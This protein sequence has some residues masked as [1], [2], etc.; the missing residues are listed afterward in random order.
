M[1]LID[2]PADLVDEARRVERR[3]PVDRDGEG[4]VEER[5]TEDLDRLAAVDRILERW[6]CGDHGVEADAVA[7]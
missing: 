6:E 7:Q 5:V 4:L 1:H 3:L 2:D